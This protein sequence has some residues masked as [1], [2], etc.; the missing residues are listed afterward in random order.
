M[1]TWMGT[2][3]GRPGSVQETLNLSSPMS[4]T[5]GRFGREMGAVPGEE[6]GRGEGGGRE[7]DR[8]VESSG[9]LN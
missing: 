2:P 4:V 6:R 5:D 3:W 9:Q 7:R 1:Y 8:I